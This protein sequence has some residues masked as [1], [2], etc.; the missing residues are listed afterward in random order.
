MYVHIMRSLVHAVTSALT[1]ASAC[2][3]AG[4]YHWGYM[5]SARGLLEPLPCSILHPNI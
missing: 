5:A 2:L 1:N 4:A 3:A